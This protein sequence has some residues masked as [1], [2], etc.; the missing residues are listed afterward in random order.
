MHKFLLLFLLTTSYANAF[1]I[2]V[3][4]ETDAS[5]IHSNIEKSE[6]FDPYIPFELDQKFKTIC[7]IRDK[8][9]MDGLAYILY[10]NLETDSY[11]IGLYNGLDGS[12]QMHGPF[13]K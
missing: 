3:C 9:M 5:F 10:K 13:I 6:K 7:E 2:D 11:F 8:E 4:D 12:N 1:E